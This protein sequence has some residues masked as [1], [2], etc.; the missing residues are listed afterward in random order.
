M[1]EIPLKE[2]EKEEEEEEEKLV[3]V[4]EVVAP[5]AEHYKTVMGNAIDRCTRAVSTCNW[6]AAASDD[7]GG[8][9]GFMQLDLAPDKLGFRLTGRLCGSLEHWRGVFQ[10][11][12][13]LS[14]YETYHCT[15]EQS[16][17]V[18]FSASLALPIGLYHVAGI[19]QCYEIESENAFRI[20]LASDAVAAQLHAPPGW[21]TSPLNGTLALWFCGIEDDPHCVDVWIVG[22][23]QVY[24]STLS[25]LWHF[26]MFGCAPQTLGSSL[27]SAL[28]KRQPRSRK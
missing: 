3:E 12:Q 27:R 28:F 14:R 13:G 1:E 9:Y 7:G 18:V 5:D 8:S 17:I 21:F 10:D 23:P 16:D 4:V 25:A 6:D 22:W 19:V 20:V 24:V 2:E 11:E 26:G 15:E